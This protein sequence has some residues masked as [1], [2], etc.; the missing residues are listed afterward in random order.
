MNNAI[1]TGGAGFIGSHLAD[2]IIN[3]YDRIYLIDNLVRTQSTRNIN[4]LLN[5]Q[6]FVF[7]QDDISSGRNYFDTTFDKIEIS[8][9]YHL[10]ATRISRCSVYPSEGHKYLADGGFNVVKFCAERGIKLFFSS[11]ASVY[12]NPRKLPILESDPYE[13][14]TLYGSAK[15]YTENLIRTFAKSNGLKHSIC[16]F[17]SVYGDR[18]DC[19]GVYT[20]IIFNWLNNIKSGLREV[21]VYGNP[22]EKILDL[23]YVTDVI[24]A[25]NM[26][27]SYSN[28][29]VYNVST[30]YGVTITQ[31]IKVIEEVTGVSLSV[32][33]LPENRIDIESKRIGSTEKL[34]QIGW[35]PMNSLYDGIEKT[36][37]WIN[38]L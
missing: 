33:I 3:E 8:T 37:K 17:F 27:T 9:M 32:N 34:R 1:I 6:K 4:H 14:H 38:S 26:V 12:N 2:S 22:D 25:I 36:Y 23:V 7:I 13:P 10:A 18:M 19:E 28:N 15:Y 16:R 29:D 24:S 20:E 5:D 11:T 30:E 31:L 21:T 35:K